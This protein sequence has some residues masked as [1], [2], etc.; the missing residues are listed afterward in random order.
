MSNNDNTAAAK[1]QHQKFIQQAVANG[2]IWGLD[3]AQEGTAMSASSEDEETDVIP[4]WSDKALALASAKD[5]WAGYELFSL[6]L[7]L[8]LEQTVIQL[9]NDNIIIGTNWDP[10]MFGME[11][12]PVELALE[13]IEELKAQKKPIAFRHYESLA[14]YED[15]TRE[16]HDNLF[17]EDGE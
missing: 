6:D 12:H 16:A 4:F 10:A 5:G 14:E 9:A 1:E 17:G 7:P 8:F 13:L 11:S 2:E 3:H 15:M